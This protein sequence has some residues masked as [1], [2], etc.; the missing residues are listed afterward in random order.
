[1]DGVPICAKYCDDWFDACKNDYTCAE[2]WLEDFNFTSSVYSCPTASKCLKF[3]EVSSSSSFNLITRGRLKISWGTEC[4]QVFF[5]CVILKVGTFEA[6]L[7]GRKFLV[8]L[9]YKVRV[10]KN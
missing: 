8:R 3:S 7:H 4:P 1:M 6:H 10:P 9:G 2:N 5:E